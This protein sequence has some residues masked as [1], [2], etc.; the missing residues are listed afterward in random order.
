MIKSCIA[1]ILFFT[2][3]LNAAADEMTLHWNNSDTLSGKL[4][5][6]DGVT[7]ALL[8]PV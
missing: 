4:L 5:K 7:A 6:A 1:A 8:V 3:V 2:A